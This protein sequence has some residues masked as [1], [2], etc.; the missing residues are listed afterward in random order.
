MAGLKGQALGLPLKVVDAEY[1]LSGDRLMLLYITEE[2]GDFRPLIRSLSDH[3]RVKV[4]LHQVGARDGAKVV[5]GLGRCG[6]ALCCAM[7]LA[8]FEPVTMKMAKEQHLPPTEDYLTGQCGR[9]KCC[10]RYEYEHYV[11]LN[12]ALPRIGERVTTPHGTARVVVGHV[13][14]QSVSVCLEETGAV[15]EL[16]LSHISRLEA[17]KE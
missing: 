2:K 10:L 13:L 11:A 1:T 12:K 7:W 17:K 4:E 9:L 6:L 8:R 5:G 14:K 16:P 3:F 15:L